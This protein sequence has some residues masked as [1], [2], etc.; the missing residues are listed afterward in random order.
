MCGWC[1]G[2]SNVIHKI[3]QKFNETFDFEIISGGMI[4]GEREGPIGEIADYII[5]AIPDLEKRTGVLMG[6][7]YKAKIKNRSLYCSSYKP[8]KALEV[9]KNLKPEKA[10]EFKLLMQEKHFKDGDDLT[11]DNIYIEIA[12]KCSINTNQFISLLNSDTFKTKAV[13]NFQKTRDWGVSSFPT[14]LIEHNGQL[15]SLA[16]GYVDYEPLE[17]LFNQIEESIKKG[18]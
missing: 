6:E 10:F 11:S 3:Y 15:Y 13:S 7:F 5:K 16:Q 4:I 14:L 2:F 17:E 8:S 1:Y 9:C 12:R 18:E